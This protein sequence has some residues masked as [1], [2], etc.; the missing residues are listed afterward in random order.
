[1]LLETI[2]Q[3]WNPASARCGKLIKNTNG[4]VWHYSVALSDDLALSWGADGGGL[5]NVGHLYTQPLTEDFIDCDDVDYL[6]L[7]VILNNLTASVKAFHKNW[8]YNIQGWNC[9]HWSRLAVSGKAI[10][11][12]VA[13]VGGWASFI[14]GPLF[15]GCLFNFLQR[16]YHAEQVLM[17]QK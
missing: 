9:E 15:A 1:M 11:T 17:D 14:I 13:H 3:H 7:D 8:W 6:S 4:V 10:S 16:H 5:M 2:K 12:Q